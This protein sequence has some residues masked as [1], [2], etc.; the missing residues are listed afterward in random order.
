ML[1]ET[2]QYVKISLESPLRKHEGSIATNPFKFILIEH[3]LTIKFKIKCRLGYL[4]LSLQ[5]PRKVTSPANVVQVI[6]QL[7]LPR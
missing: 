7:Q 5:G 3:M 1:F 2:A 6:H 4:L